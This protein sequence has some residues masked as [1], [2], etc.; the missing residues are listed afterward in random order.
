MKKKTNRC[1]KFYANIIK[2]EVSTAAKKESASVKCNKCNTFCVFL[3]HCKAFNFFSL[4]KLISPVMLMAQRE[5]NV[6][7]TPCS[8]LVI[9]IYKIKEC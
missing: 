3:F 1:S 2:D 8:S 6:S 9:P 4:Y 7:D 5:G